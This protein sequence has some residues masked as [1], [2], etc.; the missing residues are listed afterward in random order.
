MVAPSRHNNKETLH[1]RQ[2]FKREGKDED[3]KGQKSRP[4]PTR[5]QPQLESNNIWFDPIEGP[6][7]SG[8][9]KRQSA[10]AKAEGIVREELKRLGRSE[11]ELSQRPKSDPAKLA[12][13][14][15]LRR[16]TTL[17]LP[18]IATRLHAGTWKSLNT[19]LHRWRKANE[20]RL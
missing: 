10:E 3:E 7:H 17:T 12:L 1:R 18:W 16:E 13:A 11:G 6:H 9:L 4:S 14:A 2:I 15:R 19:K 8:Q 20:S 5:T